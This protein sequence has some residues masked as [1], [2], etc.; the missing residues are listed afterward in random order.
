MRVLSLIFCVLMFSVEVH[1]QVKVGEVPLD[2]LGVSVAGKDI[3]VSDNKGKVVVA[4]IW[5]SWCRDCLNELPDLE[6]IQ[7]LVGKDRIEIVAINML[8]DDGDFRKIYEKMTSY[9]MTITRG[10]REI[11]GFYK[12]KEIPFMVIIGK[13]GKVAYIHKGFNKRIRAE[14]V[15]ELNS[16]LMKEG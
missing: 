16:E 4:T 15:D 7:R 13:D 9:E 11:I 1:A 12:A 10:T 14:F 6:K 2:N 3:K 8:E 5:A